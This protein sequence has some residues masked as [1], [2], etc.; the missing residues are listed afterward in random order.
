MRDLAQSHSFL[1]KKSSKFPPRILRIILI[2]IVI[3]AIV[4]FVI[5]K[6][7]GGASGDSESLHDAPAGL[8]PVEVSGAPV[9]VA[10]GVNLS[11]DT[12]TLKNVAGADGGTATATRVY[13]NG[14]YTLTVNATLPDP[15]ANRYQVW[16]SDGTKVYDANFMEGSKTSWSDTFRDTDKYSKVKNIWITREITSEDNKPERHIMEGSF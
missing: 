7:G 1:P 10:N 9:S 4:Y 8:T 14:G 13:G 3:S 15:H 6:V 5:S 12:I 2:V 16:L 11:S